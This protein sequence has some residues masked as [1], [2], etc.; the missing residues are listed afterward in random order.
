[1]SLLGELAS[2]SETEGLFNHSVIASVRE[3]IQDDMHS[4]LDYYWIA[5]A[6][7]RDDRLLLPASGAVEWREIGEI[8][9]YPPLSQSDTSP[10]QGRKTTLW[11][12]FTTLRQ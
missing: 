5:T 12:E 10:Y 4:F 1:M 8:S 7:P 6:S 3:A 2:V 9:S 11:I